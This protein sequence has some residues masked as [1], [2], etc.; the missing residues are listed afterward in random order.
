MPNTFYVFSLVDPGTD[1][2][3]IKFGRTQHN[4]A[5]KRYP[6]KER[7]DY[8]MKLLLSLRGRLET[9]TRIENWWKQEAE[10]KDLFSRF[11]DSQFHGT[12]ECVRLTDEELNQMLS[13]S[14]EMAKEE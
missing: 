1:A 13:H 11:S 3:L 6:A 2:A 8:K 4:D 7:R 12:T 5:I 9:M 10:E 14:K